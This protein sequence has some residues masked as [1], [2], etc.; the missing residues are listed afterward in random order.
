MEVPSNL[1]RAIRQR[2]LVPPAAL[3]GY[4]V[5]IV[6]VGAI[7]R[8][9]A[10]QLAAMG[11][12]S[13][14]LVD[15]D[16]VG[17]ENLAV[18]GFAHSDLGRHKVEATAEACRAL[19]PGIRIQSEPERFRRLTFHGLESLST[20]WRERI[21]TFCCVD[22][23]SSRRIVW[24]TARYRSAF[25]V[26]GRMVAETLRVICSVSPGTDDHYATTLFEDARAHPAPCTGRSTLYAASVAAGVM[27]S[28]FAMHMRNQAPAKDVLLQLTSDEWTVL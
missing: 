8:Q 20:P 25:F 7:G 9:V 13:M 5:L 22:T 3:A 21:A 19:L 14:T 6:G 2:D 17:I 24:E 23:M 26:D 4:H 1:D 11:A 16:I 27:L 28:R 15:P 12:E 10:V 18:Q